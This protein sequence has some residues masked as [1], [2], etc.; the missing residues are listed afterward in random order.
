MPLQ[1]KRRIPTTREV[2]ATFYPYYKMA[3]YLMVGISW[4]PRE[5]KVRKWEGFLR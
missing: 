1:W 3:F 2:Q 4:S 5:I